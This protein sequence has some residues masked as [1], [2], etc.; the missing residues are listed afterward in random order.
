MFRFEISNVS[1]AMEAEQI[2]FA[3]NSGIEE[4]LTPVSDRNSTRHSTLADVA[5]FVGHIA[6]V[7]G[8][9]KT[10]MEI[11]KLGRADESKSV[12]VTV[13]D[14]DTGRKITVTGNDVEGISEK[15][16]DFLD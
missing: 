9:V 7:L 1:D 15:L 13:E 10:L 16:S 5:V 14:E 11:T 3:A 6:I 4:G 8:A 2:L 12:S